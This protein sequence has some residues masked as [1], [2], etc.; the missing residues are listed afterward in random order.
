MAHRLIAVIGIAITGVLMFI[1]LTT[2]TTLSNAGAGI[3][4]VI[5]MALALGAVRR[6]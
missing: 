6:I 4:T 2:Y 5:I 3:A 1:G